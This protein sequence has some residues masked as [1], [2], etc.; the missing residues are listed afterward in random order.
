[1][2]PAFRRPE[3]ASKTVV[4]VYVPIKNN[5]YNIFLRFFLSDR[6]TDA[7]RVS[8][9]RVRIHIEYSRIMRGGG[10]RAKNRARTFFDP[11]IFITVPR[12]RAQRVLRQTRETD[13]CSTAQFAGRGHRQFEECTADFGRVSRTPRGKIAKTIR[14]CTGDVYVIN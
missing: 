9:S 4:N 8:S 5:T 3:T 6:P 14:T 12:P 11:S 2:W 7:P 13:A 10:E 1:M